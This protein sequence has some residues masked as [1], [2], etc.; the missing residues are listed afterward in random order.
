MGVGRSGACWLGVYSTL[1]PVCVCARVLC[2]SLFFQS[3]SLGLSVSPG[4]P[5]AACSLASTALSP[6]PQGLGLSCS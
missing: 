4:F 5:G 2:L 6:A 1:L 3:F